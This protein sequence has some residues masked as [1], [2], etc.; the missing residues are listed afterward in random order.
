MPRQAPAVHRAKPTSGGFFW[1]AISEHLS[2]GQAHCQFKACRGSIT[3]RGRSAFLRVLLPLLSTGGEVESP[4]RRL[5]FELPAI[6]PRC[7]V[8]WGIVPPQQCM[9]CKSSREQPAGGPVLLKPIYPQAISGIGRDY[10]S[11]SASGEFSFIPGKTG[12]SCGCPRVTTELRL[13]VPE[14]LGPKAII[15]H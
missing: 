14:D 9:S 13:H 1:Y 15:G 8:F 10:P 3:K 5:H 7:S 4:L 11:L 2:F 6:L 12:D